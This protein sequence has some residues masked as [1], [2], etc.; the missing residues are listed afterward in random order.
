MSLPKGRPHQGN[1]KR[2]LK[3]FDLFDSGEY[4]QKQIATLVEMQGFRCSKQTVRDALKRRDRY[5]MF[6]ARLISRFFPLS[7]TVKD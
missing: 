4:S 3:I 5:Q 6:Y 7:H 2:D 1:V